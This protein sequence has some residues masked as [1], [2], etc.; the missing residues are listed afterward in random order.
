MEKQFVV[1]GICVLVGVL[2]TARYR[3]DM[4][5]SWPKIIKHFLKSIFW[6]VFVILVFVLINKYYG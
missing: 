5:W 6:A 3:M 4:K 2:A 1:L